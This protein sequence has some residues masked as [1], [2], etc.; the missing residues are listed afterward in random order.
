MWGILKFFLYIYALNGLY[1]YVT[2]IALEWFLWNS[3]L[4][5]LLFTFVAAIPCYKTGMMMYVDIAWPWG[6]SFIGFGGLYFGEGWY[7]RK[8]IMCGIYLLIG[9]RMAV[10][11]TIMI[12]QKKKD[13]P[14]YQYA[15]QKFEKKGVNLNVGMIT[16][17]YLQ[18]C[19]NLVVLWYPLMVVSSD[20]REGFG[21]VEYFGFFCW[22]TFYLFESM[23]DLQKEG[24]RKNK[25]TKRT[26]MRSGIVEIF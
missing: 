1:V 24:F 12:L 10:F 15:K 13:F 7:L 20:Q 5:F 2:N 4:Q 25:N 16:D 19:A 18:M 23:A 26:D 14:R 9:L 8:Y 11:G 6:V 17:I 21:L 22:L 3:L